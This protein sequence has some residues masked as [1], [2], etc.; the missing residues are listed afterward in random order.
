MNDFAKYNLGLN[1]YK[2]VKTN[3]T[4]SRIYIFL[5]LIYQWKN[6]NL[7]K[8]YSKYSQQNKL[9]HSFNVE[10]LIRVIRSIS[11]L[12][13]QVGSK[14]NLVSVWFYMIVNTFLKIGSNWKYILIWYNYKDLIWFVSIQRLLISI[15]YKSKGKLSKSTL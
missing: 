4:K 7:F 9:I 2:Y 5:I 15:Y 14:S 10:V 6:L 8:L 1:I 13:F 12:V 3:L 11:N